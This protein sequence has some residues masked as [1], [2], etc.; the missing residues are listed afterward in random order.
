M[1]LDGGGS[2]HMRF[3]GSTVRG[4]GRAISTAIVI[5]EGFSDC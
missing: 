2:T 1:N 4:G 3:G 5:R